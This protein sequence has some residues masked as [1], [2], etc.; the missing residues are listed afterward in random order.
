MIGLLIKLMVLYKMEEKRRTGKKYS[1]SLCK[2][3]E[4]ISERKNSS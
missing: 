3:N 4:S 2:L 1:E